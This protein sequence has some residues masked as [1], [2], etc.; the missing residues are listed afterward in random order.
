MVREY[1]AL[2]CA[3]KGGGKTAASPYVSGEA[4][5]ITR[6]PPTVF[7]A[8]TWAP[9]VPAEVYVDPL[10]FAGYGRA[11]VLGDDSDMDGRVSAACCS[12]PCVYAATSGL[13]LGT[14]ATAH[15]PAARGLARRATRPGRRLS[16]SRRPSVLVVELHCSLRSDGVNLASKLLVVALRPAQANS[17]RVIGRERRC[18]NSAHL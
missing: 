11:P 14:P 1:S 17:Q 9:G 8:S 5:P 2:L 4:T 12:R 10:V 6:Y 15:E 13:V 18:F 7:L 3:S 16:S